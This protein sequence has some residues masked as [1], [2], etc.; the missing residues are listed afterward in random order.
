MFPS[1]CVTVTD[2]GSDCVSVPVKWTG[3]PGAPVAAGE[4]IFGRPVC[5]TARAIDGS[6]P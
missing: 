5:E 3:S 6:S 1:G 2:H 4:Y